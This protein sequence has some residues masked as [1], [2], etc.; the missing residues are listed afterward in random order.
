VH[1]RGRSSLE[2]ERAKER[3]KVVGR[4]SSL[5]PAGLAQALHPGVLELLELGEVLGGLRRR[6]GGLTLDGA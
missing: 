6:G 3:L 5:I 1:G 2:A 4:K